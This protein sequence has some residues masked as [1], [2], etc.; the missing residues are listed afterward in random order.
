MVEQT[1]SSGGKCHAQPRVR[2]TIIGLVAVVSVA[3]ASVITTVS[4]APVRH[5]PTANI[6]PV[7]KGTSARPVQVY[8]TN[9]KAGLFETSRC[10]RWGTKLNEDKGI[11]SYR[12][13]EKQIKEDESK[14]M[15]DGCFI[16]Y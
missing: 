1:N 5:H 16:I 9:T 2:T 8:P 4:Q 14:A 13:I 3:S 11:A 15:D 6:H 10:T 7:V 12:T